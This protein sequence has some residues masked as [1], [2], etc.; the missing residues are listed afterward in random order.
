VAEQGICPVCAG[1]GRRAVSDSERRYVKMIYSYDAETDTLSC[2]N[3]GGQTMSGTA[4]GKVN[5]RIDNGEPCVHEYQGRDA[6][7]C[8]VVYTCKHCNDYYGIDSSD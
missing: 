6:G 7:R 8:Y 1:T 3:C 4:T 5:L 2:R